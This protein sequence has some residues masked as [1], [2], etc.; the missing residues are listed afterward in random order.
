MH[1]NI[2]NLR[3]NISKLCDLSSLI[4]KKFTFIGLSETWL[5]NDNVDLYAGVYKCSCDWA[6]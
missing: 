1:L 3:Q 5:H 6:I 2:R 4:D